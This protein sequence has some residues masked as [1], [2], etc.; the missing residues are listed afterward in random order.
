MLADEIPTFLAESCLGQCILAPHCE[1]QHI[2]TA[3]GLGDAATRVFGAATDRAAVRA[4]LDPAFLPADPD[5]AVL[6]ARLREASTALGL[7][8]AELRR[9]LA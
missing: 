8:S 7:S 6:T 5:V 2:G 9:R 4:L 1:R 3:R